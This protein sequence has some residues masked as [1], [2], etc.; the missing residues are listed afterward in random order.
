MM[1]QEKFI[2]TSFYN[3]GI[4]PLYTSFALLLYLR[5]SSIKL[6]FLFFTQWTPLL[7]RS[8]IEADLSISL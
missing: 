5:Y 2:S 8:V 1:F 4:R 3:A 7:S 6:L